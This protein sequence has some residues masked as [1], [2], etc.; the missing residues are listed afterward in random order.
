MN[1]N[2][3]KNTELIG[4]NFEL[5]VYTEFYNFCYKNNIPTDWNNQL[6]KNGYLSRCERIRK[7]LKYLKPNQNIIGISDLEITNKHNYV[8]HTIITREKNYDKNLQCRKCG[9]KKI[10]IKMQQS[11]SIDE[12][13]TFNF[14]CD[15][16][17]YI[18]REN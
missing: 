12:G 7:N 1:I 5:Q 6:F 3:K 8:K 9:E 17:N 14:I 13:P 18:S 11:R 10:V 15:S 4:E 2:R 16:C